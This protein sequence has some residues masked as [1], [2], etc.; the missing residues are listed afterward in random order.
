[1]YGFLSLPDRREMENGRA[2]SQLATLLAKD[3][4]SEADVS[5]FQVSLSMH[6]RLLILDY[7]KVMSNEWLGHA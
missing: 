4:V 2:Y 1:M 5:Y 6:L 7:V 3:G